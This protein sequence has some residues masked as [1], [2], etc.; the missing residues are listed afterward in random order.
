LNGIHQL[1]VYA[2]GVNI[3]GGSVHAIKKNTEVLVVASKEV[4]L[5]VGV[6]VE[7]TKYM[8]MSREQSARQNHNIKIGNTFF[9]TVEHFKYLGTRLANQNSIHEEIKYRLKKGNA[10]NLSV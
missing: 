9:E 1:L 6:N 8:I 2:D 7:K 3:L 4:G 5:H 10:C